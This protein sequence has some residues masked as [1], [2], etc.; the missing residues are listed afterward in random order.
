LK[1][2]TSRYRGKHIA[3]GNTLYVGDPARGSG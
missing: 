1:V 2:Q 3:N